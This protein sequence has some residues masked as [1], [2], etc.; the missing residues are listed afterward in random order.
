MEKTKRKT[1]KEGFGHWHGHGHGNGNG[2]GVESLVEPLLCAVCLT[3]DDDGDDDAV[4]TILW[5]HSFT[6]SLNKTLIY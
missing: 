3:V 6:Y 4:G 1:T 5:C 2:N